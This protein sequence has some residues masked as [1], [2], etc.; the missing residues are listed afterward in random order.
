LRDVSSD[1]IE[2]FGSLDAQL[3]LVLRAARIVPD[4]IWT[5]LAEAGAAP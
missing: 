3:L 2:S 1:L 5:R 4:E